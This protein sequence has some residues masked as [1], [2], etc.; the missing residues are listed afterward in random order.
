MAQDA[1]EAGEAPVKAAPRSFEKG[2]EVPPGLSDEERVA[3]NRAQGDPEADGYP[4]EKALSG[5]KGKGKL[6]AQLRT[7][8]G[9]MH[10][11]LF[12][13]M[14]PLT[15]ANFVGLARGRRPF[16]EPTPNGKWKLG[17]YYD[18]TQFHRVIP[19]FMIQGGD[20][21]ASGMGGPGY[22]IPDEIIQ[23]V[24]FD[25]AGLLAMANRGPGTG[26]AQFFVTLGPTTHLNG[27]HTIF[28]RCTPDSAVV[29]AEIAAVQRDANDR[30]ATPMALESVEIYRGEEPRTGA[31]LTSTPEA[32]SSSSPE[33]A[34][35]P[36][37]SSSKPLDAGASQSGLPTKEK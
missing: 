20:P 29:A 21:T 2:Q 36:E 30:P 1:D 14:T 5:L 31:S 12:E 22:V 11:E 37:A 8:K 7:S 35:S 3:Y 6:W 15:V 27:K 26:G 13:R 9:E 32:G 25:R 33:A 28:G 18:N 24:R 4:L 10:C 34:S 17:K 16:R 23:S 19:E